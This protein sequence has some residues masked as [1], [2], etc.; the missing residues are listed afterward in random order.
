MSELSK[1][2]QENLRR[3]TRSQLRVQSSGGIHSSK[4]QQSISGY[5]ECENFYF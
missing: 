3:Q 5:F 4:S 1:K 2:A